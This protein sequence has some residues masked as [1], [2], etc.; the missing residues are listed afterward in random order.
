MNAESTVGRPSGSASLLKEV[1]ERECTLLAHFHA[2]LED[3]RDALL[4]RD[5]TRIEAASRQKQSALE[6]LATEETRLRALMVTPAGRLAADAPA[7]EFPALWEK[8]RAGWRFAQTSNQ[9][10]NAVL[11]IHQTSVLRGLGVLRQAAGQA[12]TYRADGRTGGHYLSA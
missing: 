10:N 7:T 2:L 6:A 8:V 12:E 9:R 5:A 11:K 4:M 1:L 3:E